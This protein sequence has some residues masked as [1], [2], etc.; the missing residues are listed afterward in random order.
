MLPLVGESVRLFL[1]SKIS[2]T[3]LIETSS[4]SSSRFSS[5]WKISKIEGTIKEV[6]GFKPIL[7]VELELKVN[8]RAKNI[9]ANSVKETCLNN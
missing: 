7:F 1:S 5:K 9:K 6:Q 4:D 3:L 8:V 2:S